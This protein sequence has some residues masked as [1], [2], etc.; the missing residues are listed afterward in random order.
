MIFDD[1][2]NNV[3]AIVIASNY[4]NIEAGEI[5]LPISDNNL[6]L[7]CGIYGKWESND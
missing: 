2:N 4:D 7:P 1:Y 3:A 6:V 5:G